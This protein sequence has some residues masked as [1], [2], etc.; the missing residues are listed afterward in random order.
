MST[1]SSCPSCGHK[2]YQG[3]LGGWFHVYKCKSCGTKYCPSCPGSNTGGN[4]PNCK[5][6][7]KETL[8][9]AG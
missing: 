4:C 3:A 6:D 9:T 5:S 7:K 2:P 8:G 1:F